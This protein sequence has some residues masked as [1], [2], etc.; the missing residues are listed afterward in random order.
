MLSAKRK[1]CFPILSRA[2][3]ARMKLLLTR[4]HADPAFEPQ[5]ILGGSI[6]LGRYGEKALADVE[7][8]NFN[9]KERLLNVIEG[10][11]HA[12]MAKTA[13]LIALET[14]NIFEKLNPDIVLI[15]GDRFEQLA[16]AMSAAYLNKTI[17]HI[18]GG[19][20]TGSIDESVRHA[21]TKLSHIH[22]VTNN[23]A[24]KRVIQMGE[25]P[26]M[27]FNVGSPDLE[28]VKHSNKKINNEEINARGVGE[29]IDIN[30]P[31][32]LV[33][34]HPVT[35]D[36][37]HIRGVE[38]I[39]N[40]LS[41]IKLPAIWFWPNADAGTADMSRRLRE[42]HDQKSSSGVKIR[43]MIDLLP[44]DFVALVRKAAVV[45]GNSSAGIKEAPF[46]GVPTVN[47]G[48]RQ[49]GRLKGPSV[50][51]VDAAYDAP[52][53]AQAI[54]YQLKHGKY[55]GFCGYYKPD[56]SRNIVKILSKIPLYTQKIFHES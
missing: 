28:F 39:Y 50:M 22:F 13:G 54:G 8:S 40:A 52:K 30:K 17:A 20:V 43:F 29:N 31:F 5:V 4:L 32:A 38:A 23:A 6:M 18:E 44:D 24:K 48:R 37:D 9:I 12:A 10:G 26:K 34:L 47:I 25:N 11:N 19:D 49:S 53:V 3:Y 45:V 46:L 36:L 2:Y 41:K 14:S 42:I 56:T 55:S 21:I 27:V 51:D 7:A 16:L 33:V 1:I 15:C 35:S